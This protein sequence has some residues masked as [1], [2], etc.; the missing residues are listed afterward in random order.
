[1]EVSTFSAGT[2]LFQSESLTAPLAN[3]ALRLLPEFEYPEYGGHKATAKYTFNHQ[4]IQLI[5]ITLL[6]SLSLMTIHDK[7]HL[8][9]FLDTAGPQRAEARR[10]VRLGVTPPGIDFEPK[11]AARVV[12]R[13]VLSVPGKLSRDEYL[14][15]PQIMML[16]DG[17]RHGQ[18]SAVGSKWAA[19]VAM[20]GEVEKNEL[21]HK[22]DCGQA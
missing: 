16:A 2:F 3:A 19:L 13:K 5:R 9:D 1:M 20:L 15:L 18:L 8:R 22:Y 11:G 17:I 12:P 7:L 14:S 21:L 4:L 10:I 6:H